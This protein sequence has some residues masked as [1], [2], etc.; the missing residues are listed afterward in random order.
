MFTCARSKV[1][2]GI[3]WQIIGTQNGWLS[4]REISRRLGYSPSVVSRLL[5]RFYQMNEVR[6]RQHSGR[7][8]VTSGRENDALKR[9]IRRILFANSTVLKHSWLPNRRLSTKTVRNQ[10]LCAGYNARRPNRCS[11]LTPRY[12]E[13]RLFWCH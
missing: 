11:M 4:G 7:P 6:D 13:A 1:P 2:E 5:N 8:L 9:L 3:R 12:K 10:L